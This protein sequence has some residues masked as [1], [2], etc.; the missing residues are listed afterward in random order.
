MQE[1][2]IPTLISHPFLVSLRRAL[3]IVCCG[4]WGAVRGDGVTE[5]RCLGK[6]II[7]QRNAKL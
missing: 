3:P 6:I 2:G 1:L 7:Q 5:G 4:G